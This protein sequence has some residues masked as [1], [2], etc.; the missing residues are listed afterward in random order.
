MGI[1]N[2]QSSNWP[3]LLTEKSSFSW[4]KVVVQPYCISGE[5][6]HQQ[7]ACNWLS[8]LTILILS[9]MVRFT[10][11]CHCVNFLTICG[12]NLV[13]LPVFKWNIFSRTFTWYCLFLSILQREIWIFL[14]VKGW[15]IFTRWLGSWRMRDACL[16]LAFTG[17]CCY[18]GLWVLTSLSLTGC[19]NIC[20][21]CPRKGLVLWNGC[22][23]GVSNCANVDLSLISH[24]SHLMLFR[25]I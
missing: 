17:S 4:E 8:K 9:L 20:V 5:V 2:F 18:N 11:I 19:T 16:Q 7:F 6:W 23:G 10:I 1:H 13:V 21:S 14:W 22:T 12:R 25:G 24:D 15:N 3:V